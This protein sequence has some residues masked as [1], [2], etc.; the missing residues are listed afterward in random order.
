M[1]NN[2]TMTCEWG[3]LFSQCTC[4]PLCVCVCCVR[5]RGGSSIY[6]SLPFAFL[7]RILS[8]IMS[9]YLFNFVPSC[10]FTFSPVWL[11]TLR[12]LLGDDKINLCLLYI[13]NSLRYESVWRCDTRKFLSQIDS[14]G[15][16]ESI[17]IREWRVDMWIWIYVCCVQWVER[18]FFI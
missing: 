12:L 13:I 17:H 2:T 14:N 4:V 18:I 16:M 3:V 6:I 10:S 15:I 11:T 1:F 7:H 5:F 8:S 9:L